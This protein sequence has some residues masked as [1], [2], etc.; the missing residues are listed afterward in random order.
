MNT[1]CL[2]LLQTIDQHGFLSFSK[3]ADWESANWLIEKGYIVPRDNKGHYILSP[4]G[5]E[6]LHPTIRI[7]YDLIKLSIEDIKTL[8]AILTYL[9]TVRPFIWFNGN[10]P[11]I[12]GKH[13][14]SA[15]ER[16]AK[17]FSET[18]L[19]KIGGEGIQMQDL[20]E[21]G[22]RFESFYEERLMQLEEKKEQGERVAHVIHNQTNIVGNNQSAITTGDYSPASSIIEPTTNNK[23]PKSNSVGRIIKWAGIIL[24]IIVSL[25]FIYE[26]YKQN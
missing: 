7:A 20:N 26:F 22:R 1:N 24:T 12:F 9:K 25:I 16:F 10:W 3:D 13:D 17:I 14:Y 2:K 6:F 23:S 8:D 4:K 18:G 11:D 15:S 5:K 21:N 19:T